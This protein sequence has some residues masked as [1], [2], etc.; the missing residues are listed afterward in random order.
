MTQS[1]ASFS[2]QLADDIVRLIRSESLGPGDALES[3][4]DLAKRFAVTTPTVREALRRLEATGVVELR[5]GSGTY[6]GP[7]IER[8]VLANPHRPR[9]TRSSVIELAEARLVIEPGIAA[10]A[11][12]ARDA[13]ALQRLEAATATALEPPVHGH[14]PALNFHVELAAASGNGLLRETLEALLHVR[15]DEQT[16][17]RFRY[18]D[19][20]R[21]H[22]EHRDI[23]A[24][25][26]DG[27]A[28]AAER[29]TRE[30][31]TTIRASLETAD[32]GA[33]DATGPAGAGPV[34]ADEGVAP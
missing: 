8:T 13:A 1:R 9:I 5:H 26:R 19:R 22:A 31:L 12:S 28:A 3:S 14:R 20:Q 33:P 17:I 27:D 21:D 16:E 29:L 24:A 11:A 34:G 30:H 10:L 15:A 6:I 2:E 23:L 7:G 4:R 25:V 32:F 18:D